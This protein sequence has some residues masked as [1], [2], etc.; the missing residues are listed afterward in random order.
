LKT[1]SSRGEEHSSSHNRKLEEEREVKRE[2]RRLNSSFYKEPTPA[3]TALIHRSI[4]EHITLM[5]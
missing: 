2:Q 3:I 5:A 1:A 4:D